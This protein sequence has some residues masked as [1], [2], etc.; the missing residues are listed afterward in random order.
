MTKQQKRRQCSVLSKHRMHKIL[1]TFLAALAIIITQPTL[2]T[3]VFP[4][5]WYKLANTNFGIGRGKVRHRKI[6]TKRSPVDFLQLLH[7]PDFLK[8]FH[9]NKDRFEILLDEIVKFYPDESLF[10]SK[11]S[12][13]LE[14]QFA[15]V[16]C[17]FIHYT[18]YSLLGVMFGVSDSMISLIINQ[19]LPKLA[20]FFSCYIPEKK[21][22]TAVSSL[23]PSIKYI[24]DST[25]KPTV[26]PK[27]NQSKYF[28][29]HYKTHG[30][31]TH[32]MV[33]FDGWILSLQTNIPGSVHDVRIAKAKPF[34]HIVKENEFAL[35]DPGYQGVDW[36]VSGFKASSL[37]HT[38]GAYIFDYVSREEQRTIETVNCFI[39][40]NVLTKNIK[41]HHKHE[42]L[43]F[44]IV[45]TCGWYNYRKYNN[46][47]IEVQ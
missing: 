6:Y 23:H 2:C 24:V 4:N 31:L 11:T 39:K 44:C 47:P 25:I 20:K 42:L 30:I 1:F 7:A 35:A 16:W 17:W 14:N 12:L 38:A 18:R 3:I 22:S 37:P 19:W 5:S 45:I 46:L 10:V 33:D 8:L 21:I 36:I 27:R 26:R 41:F 13:T 15:L 32:I 43:V 29:G 40:K 34:H 28:S 9:L